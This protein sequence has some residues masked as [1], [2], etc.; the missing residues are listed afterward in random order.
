ME[1][2]EAALRAIEPE[3]CQSVAQAA[4]GTGEAAHLEWRYEPVRGTWGDATAGTFRINGSARVRGEVVEWA[5]FL[6]VLRPPEVPPEQPADPPSNDPSHWRYWQR[7][8][9]VYTSAIASGVAVGFAPARPLRVD[10]GNDEAWIWLE[11]VLEEEP[12]PWPATRLRL[13]AQ[14]LGRFQG[15]FAAG[16]PVPRTQWLPRRWLRQI[17]TACEPYVTLLAA[18]PEHPLA[19]R[20]WP[21]EVRDE[22]LRLWE[23]RERFLTTLDGLPRTLRHGDPNLGNLFARNDARGEPETVAIDWSL[24]AE[25]TVG[26]DLG[27]L[28]RARTRVREEF[29]PPQLRELVFAGYCAGLRDAGWRGDTEAVTIGFRAGNALRDCFFV[30]LYE[31][32]EERRLKAAE[33][34]LGRS[35]AGFYDAAGARIRGGV[36]HAREARSLLGIS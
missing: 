35:L 5:A 17:V 28:L 18:E 14:H 23:E 32:M 11:A 25:A 26:E 19:T 13:V 31:L 2:V 27:A 9:L 7:E 34:R 22:V 36:A 24:I 29:T 15:V 6:K 12:R 30:L 1:D 4:L 8:A 33:V 20:L 21:G 10:I 16:R 3:V